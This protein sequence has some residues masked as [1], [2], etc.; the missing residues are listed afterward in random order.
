MLQNVY[1]TIDVRSFPSRRESWSLVA[2]NLCLYLSPYLS[3]SLRPSQTLSVIHRCQYDTAS[4]QLERDRAHDRRRRRVRVDAGRH[5]TQ[6]QADRLA[7]Q[8]QLGRLGGLHAGTRQILDANVH[9]QRRVR[10]DV[11]LRLLRLLVAVTVHGRHEARRNQ[12]PLLLLVLVGQ[13]VALLVVRHDRIAV[14]HLVRRAEVGIEQRGGVM[15]RRLGGADHRACDGLDGAAHVDVA[16]ARA[17]F[18]HPGQATVAGE[19]VVW[20]MSV[21]WRN[22]FY[23]VAT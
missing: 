5:P 18:E 22:V 8:R 1:Y 23:Y 19:L 3:H 16:R 4:Q 2:V 15:V 14:G 13:L 7:R 20:R 10:F 6:V 12:Q 17:Q 21:L 9:Q 11:D